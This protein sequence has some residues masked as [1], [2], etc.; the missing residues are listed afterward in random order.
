VFFRSGDVRINHMV[1]FVHFVSSPY[2]N[3]RVFRLGLEMHVL[4][5]TTDAAVVTEAVIASAAGGC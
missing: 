4:R 5:S 3:C 2:L 1:V